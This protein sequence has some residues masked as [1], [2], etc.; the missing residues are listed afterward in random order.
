MRI[1]FHVIGLVAVILVHNMLHASPIA[2]C[3][4]PAR[5]SIHRRINE[6]K[7]DRKPLYVA[8]RLLNSDRMDLPVVATSHENLTFRE[9]KLSGKTDFYFL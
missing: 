7:P 6:L 5:K 3:T 1:E 4:A 8:Y 2:D 9:V